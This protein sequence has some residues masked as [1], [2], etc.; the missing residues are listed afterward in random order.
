MGP[1]GA[2]WIKG[3]RFTKKPRWLAEREKQRWGSKGGRDGGRVPGSECACE[4]KGS[5]E[6][7]SWCRTQGQCAAGYRR[8]EGAEDA[9]TDGV[10]YLR[11]ARSEKVLSTL[12]QVGVRSLCAAIWGSLPSSLN[13]DLRRSCCRLAACCCARQPSV[14]VTLRAARRPPPAHDGC[15]CGGSVSH[16]T[17]GAGA[18]VTVEPAPSILGHV[19]TLWNKC[20]ILQQVG[21]N[22]FKAPPGF[23]PCGGAA[24]T[25][26]RAG[27]D[28]VSR[29]VLCTG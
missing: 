19:S 17:V 13:R 5:G 20:D 3:E 18:G 11:F 23:R 26:T 29:S 8:F 24:R 14:T 4:V 6:S 25:M 21:S 10:F 2:S 22:L 15:V 9:E 1:D 12:P 16:H 27:G 28:S 7:W